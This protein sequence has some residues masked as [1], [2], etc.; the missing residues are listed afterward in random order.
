[1]APM[2][3]FYFA[4]KAHRTIAESLR[5]PRLQVQRYTLVIRAGEWT[6]GLF[7]RHSEEAQLSCKESWKQQKLVLEFRSQLNTFCVENVFCI[8]RGEWRNLAPAKK[9]GASSTPCMGLSFS[10]VI[11]SAGSFRQTVVMDQATCQ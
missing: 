5:A 11:T 6:E 10:G 7:A 8:P 3:M 9:G 2:L 4:Y 1:M